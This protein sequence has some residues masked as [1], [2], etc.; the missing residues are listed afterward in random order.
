MK[1]NTVIREIIKKM[2]GSLRVAVEQGMVVEEG[3]TVMGGVNFG[4]EPYLITLH[5][6]CRISSDVIFINHDGGTWAFRNQWNEYADVIKYGRIEIGEETF[7][8]ARSVIM[9][10]VKIGRN[11]VIGAGSVVT[12]DV[13]DETVAVGI[14]ARRLCSTKEYAEKCLAGMPA[15]FDKESY[16]A[17][18][19]E[20]LLKHI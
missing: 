2:K 18:K 19:K 12:K 11:C 8:G 10:G 3:V 13:P 20:Y 4:C 1:L 7:V 14:P 17:N 9:P 5:K 6:N 16:F 15:D